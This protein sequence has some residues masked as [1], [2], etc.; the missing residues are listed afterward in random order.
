MFILKILYPDK[1]KDIYYLNNGELTLGS[2]SS[3]DIVLEEKTVSRKHCKIIVKKHEPLYIIDRGSK[4]GIYVNEKKTEEGKLYNGDRILLGKIKIDVEEISD[5]DGMKLKKGDKFIKISDRDSDE[6]RGLNINTGL[7]IISMIQTI[8][9]KD[10]LKYF[11]IVNKYILSAKDVLIGKKGETGVKILYLE[12]DRELLLNAV[13]TDEKNSI[14]INNPEF[15]YADYKEYFIICRKEN[16][17]PLTLFT[18]IINVFDKIFC[19]DDESNHA[20]DDPNIPEDFTVN[21]DFIFNSKK[22]KSLVSRAKKLAK[23][24]INIML[25]GESGVGKELLAS[26]IHFHS[27]RKDKPFVT[28]NCA[29]I[30]E[31]LL[32]SELFGY[33]KGAF[34]GAMNKK[35]G[36]FE[37]ANGGTL[38]LDEVTSTSSYFQAKLL[39]AIQFGEFYR[40]GGNEPIKVDVRVISATNCDIEKMMI[41]GEFRDDL[42]YRLAAE[43]MVIPPLRDRKEDIFGLINYFI[44]K[45]S[46]EHDKEI[47][48]I[49]DRALKILVSYDYPGNIRELEHE[50]SK[51][52]VLASRGD[53]LREKYISDRIKN[54]KKLTDVKEE[55]WDLN[56]NIEKLEKELIIRGLEKFKTKSKLAEKLNI[57]RTTLDMKIKKYDIEVKQ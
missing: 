12:G 51:M 16:K 47:T 35:I 27:K 38:F 55:G 50:I 32:E 23:S 25:R 29:A 43:D 4:N 31:N 45:Y 41:N 21:P 34:T 2:D 28:L 56:R 46:K 11:D 24:D 15:Y 22:I 5:D 26:F 53:I 36:K 49:S 39:R 10:S 40:L 1:R 13:E 19:C 17:F 48:G 9:S 8:E 6:T 30:P 33:E 3:N 42:Y 44:K 7:S 14:K 52:V 57:S 37:M 20:K 54:K 18:S